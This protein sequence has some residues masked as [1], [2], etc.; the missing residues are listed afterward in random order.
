MVVNRCIGINWRGVGQR[1]AFSVLHRVPLLAGLLIT[2]CFA[3]VTYAQAP[4]RDAIF[5]RRGY[6]KIGLGTHSKVQVN[7]PGGLRLQTGKGQSHLLQGPITLSSSGGTVRVS[8]SSS[9][10]AAD[11][12]S[13]SASDSQTPLETSL[14]NYRGKF[15]LSARGGSMRVVNELLIDDWLK[16]VLPAEIGSDSAPEALKAQAVAARS[17]AIYRLRKPPHESAGYDFCTGVHCQA[18]KGTKGETEDSNR[19]C[20]ETLGIVLIAGGDVMNGVYHNVCGGTTSAAEEVWDSPPLPG[21]TPVFDNRSRGVPDLSSDHAAAGFILN[22]PPGT[23][24]DPS[25]PGYANYAK[26][27]FRWEKEFNAA[28]LSRITGVRGIRSIEVVDRRPSGRVRKVRITGDSGSKTVEKELPIRKMFDLWSGLFI[29]QPEFSGG[30][31]QKV[32]FA[33]AGNGHGVGLCQH[34]ARE[35]GRR[36]ATF[37][38]ILSHYYPGAQVQK[39]YRP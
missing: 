16:G 33:G 23:F 12:L 15:V 29:I 37:T 27:Y 26:K 1:M 38:Q 4:C 35:L 6:V 39:I 31:L 36:G 25:N 20:E 5:A 32:T 18:Y 3:G 10:S 24:C 28:Q 19:G 8:G 13:V 7:A 34:G 2:S 17:E 14:G 22:P 21:L 30:R 9:A 11:V